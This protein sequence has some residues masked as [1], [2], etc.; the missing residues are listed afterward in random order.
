MKLEVTRQILQ[1]Y[2][3]IKFREYPSNRSRNPDWQT[4]RQTWRI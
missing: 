3:N 1:K 4:D 2:S